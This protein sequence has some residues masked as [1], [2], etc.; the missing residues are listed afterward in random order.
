MR[1]AIIGDRGI[2]ARYSGFST[3]VEQLAIRLVEEHAIDV[4]VYCRTN[5]YEEREPVWR[6]VHRVFLPAPGGKSFESLIHSTLSIMHAMFR[7]Y[8]VIFVL[9]PGNAPLCWPLRFRRWP[10]VIHTDGLG[11]KRRK[12]SRLQ[13]AYY[14]WSERLSGW[15]ADWLVTDS[16]AMQRYYAEEYGVHSSFIPYSGEV[17]PPPSDEGLNRFGLEPG[18]FYLAVARLEPENNVDLIIHE[19]RAT[20]CARPLVVVGGNP[21]GT[22]YAQAILNQ[23]DQRIRCLDAVWDAAVLN[24]LY[25]NCYCYLHGHEVGGTNPSLLR[26]MQAGA[27]CVVVD[28]VFNREVVG[29]A[30][31][32]FGK[33]PG[34]LAALLSKIEETPTELARRGAELR[35]RASAEYRWDA[36]AAAFTTL[37]RTLLRD[38]RAGRRPDALNVYHPHDFRTTSP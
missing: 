30:G 18:G 24:G 3:L 11:W 10:V 7:R 1:L 15:V 23:S 35:A 17:G 37:F 27:P 36:I 9:D 29:E 38:R 13:R 34:E 20:S 26:A 21:Y 14:R 6:G 31:L 19:Y 4:T 12:W 32:L 25:A 22:P 16:R 8:D 28:V 2:P 33:G 5:Y